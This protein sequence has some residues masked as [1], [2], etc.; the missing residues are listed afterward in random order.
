LLT[1][2]FRRAEAR[3]VRFRPRVFISFSFLRTNAFRA[4]KRIVNSGQNQ[5]DKNYHDCQYHKGASVKSGF[6]SRSDA[7]FAPVI[8]SDSRLRFGLPVGF[9]SRVSILFHKSISP[10]FC[11]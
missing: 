2:L 6:L 11:P 3:V 8:R 9:R 4:L 10:D 5:N 7:G 1:R